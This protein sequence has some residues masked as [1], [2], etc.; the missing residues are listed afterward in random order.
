[1]FKKNKIEGEKR[2]ASLREG[3]AASSAAQNVP[4]LENE[5]VTALLAGSK[6][7]TTGNMGFVMIF[8]T[9]ILRPRD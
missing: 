4:T 1:M 5:D 7:E 3:E 9:L 8:F 2:Q 6:M